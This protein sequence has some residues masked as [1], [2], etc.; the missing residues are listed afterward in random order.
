MTKS[1]LDTARLICVQKDFS[2]VVVV[3][4]CLNDTKRLYDALEELEPDLVE[5]AT[6]TKDVLTID[7]NAVTSAP[8]L[9]RG[10]CIFIVSTIEL[11]D[12]TLD[13]RNRIVPQLYLHLDGYERKRPD[14]DNELNLL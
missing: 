4:D 5:G 11:V 3:T 7:V 1:A 13:E 9:R 2:E 10:A 12:S 6:C 14:I 8:H